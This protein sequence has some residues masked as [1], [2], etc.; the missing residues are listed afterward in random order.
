[1]AGWHHW[2]NAHRFAQT[3]GESEGQGNLECCSPWGCKESAMTYW[4]NNNERPNEVCLWAA[5]GLPVCLLSD[6]ITLKDS[7]MSIN[8]LFRKTDHAESIYKTA[9]LKK[10]KD[11]SFACLLP[12]LWLYRPWECILRAGMQIAAPPTKAPHRR[13]LHSAR[14]WELCLQHAWGP[15]SFC[16]GQLEKKTEKSK[17]KGKRAPGTAVLINSV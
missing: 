14:L 10:K 9:D 7:K 2:L 5:Q 16:W 11:L 12:C 8:P 6:V 1:M 17:A 13:C 15:R 3:L 4:L